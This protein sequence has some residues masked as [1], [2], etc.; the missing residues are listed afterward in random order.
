MKAYIIF[1]FII[2]GNLSNAVLTD[3]VDSDCLDCNTIDTNKTE[4]GSSCIEC[5]LAK[6]SQTTTRLDVRVE[7]REAL[8]NINTKIKCEPDKPNACV[9]IEWAK[10]EAI[11][12]KHCADFFIN[13]DGNLGELGQL[14]SRLVSEDI[15][16]EGENS[17]FLK[18]YPEIEKICPNYPK[19]TTGVRIGFYTYWMEVL[20]FFESTCNP[21]KI[22]DNKDVPNGPAVGLY[23]M[24]PK[25]STR[26]WRGPLC[27]VSE[28][29]IKTA[30][31]NT[32]CAF[33]IFRALLKSGKIFGQ[34]DPKTGKL[35]GIRYWHAQNEPPLKHK[36]NKNEVHNRFKRYVPRFPL[37]HGQI[38]Q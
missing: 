10:N 29:E 25:P 17:V 32:G 14:M 2:L 28:K 19:F 27:K 38:T 22:N 24:E 35:S 12:K 23:Q 3:I 9:M 36:N 8:A 16:K 7:A 13:E 18:N 20:A 15:I 6:K 33:E 34:R 31:G 4:A 37:C 26:S 5:D 30:K 21:D 1:V 11:D